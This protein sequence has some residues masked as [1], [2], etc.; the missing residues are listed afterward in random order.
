MRILVVEDD[1]TLCGTISTQLNAE[2]W[3]SERCYDGAEAAA[4]IKNGYYDLVILDCLLPGMNGV[5]IIGEVRRSGFSAPIIMVTAL[6][7][8]DDRVNG[9]DAGAD[10]YLVKPFA[11]NELLARVR[12]LLRRPTEYKSSNVFDCGGVKY[13]PDE[14]ILKSGEKQTRLSPKENALLQYFLRHDGQTLRREQILCSVWGADT[15]VEDGN[16]D[17]YIYF[18]RRRLTASGSTAQINTI[19]GIGYKPEINL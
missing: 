1:K 2:G 12:A 5:E 11:M 18:L 9:L 17:N 19:R 3:D 4:L 16:L 15:D 7:G 13:H 10:D 14:L 6:S 8:T